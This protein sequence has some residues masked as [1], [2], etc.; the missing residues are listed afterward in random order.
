MA[1]AVGHVTRVTSPKAIQI[2]IRDK[3]YQWRLERD[4]VVVHNSIFA[5]KCDSGIFHD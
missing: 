3:V 2:A 1:G 4:V 5:S